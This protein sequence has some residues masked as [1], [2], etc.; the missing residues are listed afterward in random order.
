MIQYQRQSAVFVIRLQKRNLRGDQYIDIVCVVNF[1][2]VR[3][4]FQKLMPK[5]YKRNLFSELGLYGTSG[6]R[7]SLMFNLIHQNMELTLQHVFDIK[8]AIFRLTVFRV[9]FNGTSI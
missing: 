3:D 1:P 7:N 2:P 8:I 4:L 6:V 9:I 5:I